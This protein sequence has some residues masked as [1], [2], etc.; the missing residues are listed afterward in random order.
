MEVV[1]QL[2]WFYNRIEEDG[3]IGPTHISLYLALVVYSQRQDYAAAFF[4][5]R[6]AIM[7][8]AKIN[9]RQT[10]NRRMNEIYEYGYIIYTP[11]SNPNISS[12]VCFKIY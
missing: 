3:R 2:G 1:N 4:I 10:Y 9:S 11:S 5:D 8:L 7:K 12:Q 6:V